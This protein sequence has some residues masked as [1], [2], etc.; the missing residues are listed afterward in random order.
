MLGKNEGRKRRGWQ[1]RWL[2]GTNDSMDVS[3]SKLWET[4]KDTEAWR[5]AVH[6]VA[7]GQTWL[8]DETMTK[9]TTEGLPWGLSGSES[10]CQCR[11]HQLDPRSRKTPC[12][13]AAK[14]TH[15]SR[16]VCALEPTLCSNRSHHRDGPAAA[17]R[18]PSSSRAPGEPGQTQLFYLSK[19]LPKIT[20]NYLRLMFAAFLKKITKVKQVQQTLKITDEH[21]QES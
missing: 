16:W 9:K 14:P 19:P 5:A 4:L 7:R 13:G 3:L 12:H 21:V 11:G 17:A 10:G 2:D 6:G 15:R 18:E 20:T 8:S 1:R